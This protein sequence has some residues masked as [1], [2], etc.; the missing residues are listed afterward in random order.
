[1]LADGGAAGRLELIRAPAAM[2]GALVGVTEEEVRE[3]AASLAAVFRHA[4]DA[5][6]QPP[7][8]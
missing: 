8:R 2:I 5:G 3:R 7:S 6:G 1:M 4:I